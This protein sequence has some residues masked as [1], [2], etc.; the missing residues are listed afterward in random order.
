LAKYLWGLTGGFY[1]L[2]WENFLFL[3]L[4]PDTGIAKLPNQ[5]SVIQTKKLKHMPDNAVKN[6]PEDHGPFGH[7][8]LILTEDF[9]LKS[10]GSIVIIIITSQIRT[11]FFN[12]GK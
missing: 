3:A 4:R 12:N 1:F 8:D 7:L 2:S 10:M 6:I 11:I 9:Y 5:P